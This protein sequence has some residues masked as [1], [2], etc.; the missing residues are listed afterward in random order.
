MPPRKPKSKGREGYIITLRKG[1]LCQALPTSAD[2]INLLTDEQARSLPTLCG[3]WVT[4]KEAE[5]ALIGLPPEL[6]AL[7]EILPVWVTVRR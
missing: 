5:K 3:V 2:V 7:V 6:L 4:E 1:D